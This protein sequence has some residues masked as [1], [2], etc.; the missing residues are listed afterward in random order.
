[1]ACGTLGIRAPYYTSTSTPSISNNVFP[2]IPHPKHLKTIPPRGRHRPPHRIKINTRLPHQLLRN[3]DPQPAQT[4]HPPQEPPEQITSSLTL[5]LS[6]TLRSKLYPQLSCLPTTHR[7]LAITQPGG[8]FYTSFNGSR[9]PRR[10]R[11][12]I[13]TH[14]P[15]RLRRRDSHITKPKPKPQPQPHPKP[16]TSPAVSI[17]LH[18]TKDR[19]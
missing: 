2:P 6:G 4:L 17:Q 8:C 14:P 15:N 18:L 12:H 9:E 19:E 1:M 11:I 10:C 16:E 3:E 7:S 13:Q 5:S